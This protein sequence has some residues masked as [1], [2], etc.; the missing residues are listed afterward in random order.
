MLN[1]LDPAEVSRFAGKYFFVVDDGQLVRS[2]PARLG[3]RPSRFGMICAWLA[4]D[5]SKDAMPGLA[6]AIAKNRFVPPTLLAPYRLDLLA[7]LSIAARDPWPE[8]NAWLADRLGESELLVEGRSAAAEIGATAAAVLL[9]ATCPIARRVRLAAGAQRADDALERQ[10][11]PL[12]RRQRES[13]GAAVVAADEK[14][15]AHCQ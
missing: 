8:V 9:S 6:K 3:G 10:R 14:R 13:Q 2:G 12:R 5:G 7:A 4:I 11:L 15:K 1:Q